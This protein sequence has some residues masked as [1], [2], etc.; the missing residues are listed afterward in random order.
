MQMQIIAYLGLPRVYRPSQNLEAANC[1][2]QSAK[3]HSTGQLTIS[4][5]CRLLSTSV[6]HISK[7]CGSPNTMDSVEQMAKDSFRIEHIDPRCRPAIVILF[8]KEDV[9][10][11]AQ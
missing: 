10:E 5:R 8:I 2:R 1:L 7:R 4:R 9:F 11:I 6:W 3:T